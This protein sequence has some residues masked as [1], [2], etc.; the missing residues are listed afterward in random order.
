MSS[1]I[2]WI[3]VVNSARGR[4]FEPDRAFNGGIRLVRELTHPASRMHGREIT[5]DKPGRSFDSFGEHRHAMSPTMDLKDRE[6]LK[7]A[8]EMAS[9][10]EHGRATQAFGRLVLIAP[11]AFLGL[12]RSEISAPTTRMVVHAVD[13]DLADAEETQI[14]SHIPTNLQ[15]A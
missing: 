10:L 1:D 15:A 5:R 2:V 3:V 12:L 4:I 6:A 14:R 7:F 11:P 13:K 9:A 8:K